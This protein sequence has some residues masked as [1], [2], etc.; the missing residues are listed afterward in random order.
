M[1]LKLFENDIKI[2]KLY[3][4]IFNTNNSSNLKTSNLKT[5]DMFNKINN[6]YKINNELDKLNNIY[7]SNKIIT[8]KF[9]PS[10]TADNV[11]NYINLNRS[12]QENQT[13]IIPII[14]L[15]PD[16]TNIKSVNFSL[17]PTNQPC[18]T[19]NLSS[20]NLPI[21]TNN[22]IINNNEI[23]TNNNNEINT[24]NNNRQNNKINNNNE[25]NNE[26]YNK[27][28][29]EQIAQLINEN[30]L[31]QKKLDEIQNQINDIPDKINNILLKTN[32]IKSKNIYNH[33]YLNTDI[34]INENIPINSII[35]NITSVSNNSNNNSS[36]S[37]INNNN[38][39]IQLTIDQQNT[40]KKLFKL[41]FENQILNYIEIKNIKKKLIDGLV[42]YQTIFDYLE[43]KKKYIKYKENKLVDNQ[44]FSIIK[45]RNNKN[46]DNKESNNKDSDSTFIKKTYL[47]PNNFIDRP[48]F[49]K[50][51]NTNIDYPSLTEF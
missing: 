4:L 33:E 41:L 23:N 30:Q 2:K 15:S 38:S 26:Q 22:L 21:K 39:K 10:F 7:K 49:G 13:K 8:D 32:D 20:N 19:I 47:I 1:D 42:D 6:Y 50:L 14:D 34:I 31:L 48:K 5:I 28:N 16:Y 24:N 43:G 46:S 35:N 9:H 3:E 18:Y 12:I 51:Y 25:Q 17:N 11:S 29:N 45:E 27:Q 36:N 44:Y 37:I 40:L